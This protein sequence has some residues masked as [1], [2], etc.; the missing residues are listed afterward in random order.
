MSRTPDWSL[1]LAEL[2]EERLGK[3]FRWGAVDCATLWGDAVLRMTGCDPLADLR[4]RWRTEAEAHA[5][6]EAEGGYEALVERRVGPRIPPRYA[7]RGDLA[8]YEGPR[9]LIVGP[10]LGMLVAIQAATGLSFVRIG[11]CAVAWRV[12][13]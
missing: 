11:A 3:R 4:G 7:R 2:V 8:G 10:V 13:T 6:I 9:G 1:R 5:L 12:G